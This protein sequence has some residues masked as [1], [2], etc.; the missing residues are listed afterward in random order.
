MVTL[1]VVAAILLG[2]REPPGETVRMGPTVPSRPERLN[3]IA[4]DRGGLP[5]GPAT[6]DRDLIVPGG[7]PPD[8]IPPIDDSTFE[9]PGDVRWLAGREP[10]LAVEVGHEARA[11]PIR[12][13]MW[14]EIVNDSIGGRPVTVTYCPLCNTGVAFLRPTIGG[15]LLDFGTSGRLFRS[16]L[17][18]YD[19]QTGTF[20]SQAPL[21]AIVGPLAG[22]RLEPIPAQIVSWRD[23]RAAHPEGRVLSQDTGF[24][25]PY[26]Q[27]PYQG[28]DSPG[29]DPYLYLGEPDPRLQATAHVLGVDV[30]G[31]RVAFPYPVL[32]RRAIGGWAAVQT[33]VGGRDI[34]V[35]WKRGTASALDQPVIASSQDVGSATAYEPRVDGRLL[36]LRATPRG[37]VDRETGSRWDLFGRAVAGPLR[38][39]RLRPLPAVDHLWF[40][41][42]AFYPDTRIYGR[43]QG[44]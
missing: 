1:A 4:R 9:A 6:V 43:Q 26:G 10:V 21:E 33:R 16:N 7:P 29:S 2:S 28:Y 19:R 41:W 22:R 42:A 36:H 5:P 40:S 38:G 37:I 11:Y 27:N 32:A 39:S 34:A 14:H 12:I 15:E 25:R 13:L 18:M 30:S 23:W 20:W 3:E 35:L 8:G 24:D 17:V 44:P 31:R